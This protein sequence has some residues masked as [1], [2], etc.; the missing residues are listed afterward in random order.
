MFDD[1]Q[2]RIP[3]NMVNAFRMY[4]TRESRSC[5]KF[6]IQVLNTFYPHKKNVL[7]KLV[8]K[9]IIFSFSLLSRKYFGGIIFLF[10]FI[11]DDC[12]RKLFQYYYFFKFATKV[13]SLI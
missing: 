5:S 11:L 12:M 9:I 4:S 8:Q 1:H 13:K 6:K 10:F 7:I 3:L 2:F